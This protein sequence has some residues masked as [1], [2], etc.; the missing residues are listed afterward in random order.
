MLRFDAL[1]QLP[2]LSTMA[3][4]QPILSSVVLALRMQASV[5]GGLLVS[6]AAAQGALPTSSPF[7]PPNSQAAAAANGETLEFAGVSTIGNKTDLIIYDKTAKKSR[8]IPLGGTVAGITAVKY[9]PRVEQAVIRT[10]GVEKNL[11]LR[12]GTGPLNAPVAVAPPVPVALPAIQA[13][14]PTGGQL[15]TIQATP[16]DPTTLPPAPP[17]TPETVAKQE[18]EARM[19]VSD[20]LEIGMAQRQ[21]YEDARRKES[22]KGAPGTTPP[23][24]PADPNVPVAIPVTPTP[25][26]N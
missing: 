14:P 6:S 4:W 8:W 1:R 18:V 15:V 19:L 7:L 11:P 25:A 21:A 17:A 20:L 16:A 22:E 26:P 24:A 5:V 12:K 2:Q 13:L 23:D 9:D 10:N 3:R